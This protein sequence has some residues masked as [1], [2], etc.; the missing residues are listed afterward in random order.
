MAEGSNPG[1]PQNTPDF[2]GNANFVVFESFDGLNIKPTRPAIGPQEMYW[3]DNLVPLGKNNLVAIPGQGTTPLYTN[4][5][6]SPIN[7]FYFFNIKTNFYCFISRTDGSAIIVDASFSGSRGNTVATFAAGFFATSTP[8]GFSQWGNQYLQIVVSN[9]YCLW[10]GTN[11]YYAGTVSPNVTVLNVGTGYTSNPSIAAASGGSGSGAT[12]AVNQRLNNQ[13]ISVNVSSAGSGYVVTDIT[14]FTNNVVST[15]IVNAGSGGTNGTFSV[16]FSGGNPIAA[17]TAT[18]TVV[19]GSIQGINITY[20]GYGYSS[21][22]TMSFSASSG[23]TNASATANYN[24]TATPQIP[25]VFSGGGGSGAQAIVNL[26]P[27]GLSGSAIE[28]FTGRVWIANKNQ[29]SYSSPG[30]PADFSTTTGGGTLTS[31]DSFLK[32]SFYSLVQS[33]GFLYCF[34]DSSIQIISNVSTNAT[35]SGGVTTVSTTFSNINAS[36]Q[37]GTIWGYSPITFSQIITFANYDGVYS[38]YGSTLQKVSAN[39]DPFF[40][41]I[42][43]S[44]ASMTVS[45]AQT[46]LY[47]VQTYIL[48]FPIIDQISGLTRNALLMWNGKRWWTASQETSYTFI[49]TQEYN[50]QLFAYGTDGTTIHQMFAGGPYSGGALQKSFRSKLYFEPTYAI[51]KRATR[52]VGTIQSLTA[53]AVPMTVTLDNYTWLAGNAS[54]S[55]SYDTSALSD[56][57]WT[58]VGQKFLNLNVSQVGY[59]LGFTISTYDPTIVFQSITMI[60]QQYNVEF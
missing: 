51:T 49:T 53:G 12:F 37:I 35:T 31:T 13:I 20:G 2:P 4:G 23:L 18:F 3:C 60:G 44:I 33:S 47:G 24:A 26:M 56:P 58:V 41:S 6:S 1:A 43:S 10:D 14:Q 46:I 59:V 34:A 42:P 21:A 15:T 5:S 30:N 7:A 17:A 16:A 57:R 25:L 19:G 36:P 39:L 29:I 9:D 8:I 38:L 32:S 27:F 48:L 52:I 45:S 22:P 11:I 40:A 28:N 50:S 54:T 55:I